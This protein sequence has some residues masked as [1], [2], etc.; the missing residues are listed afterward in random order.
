MGVMPFGSSS[1]TVFPIL[2]ARKFV[3]RSPG[4]IFIA[5]LAPI[6]MPCRR[7]LALLCQMGHGTLCLLTLLVPFR[8]MEYIIT[9]VDFFSKYSI[10][11]PS[12]DHMALMVSNAL[13]DR[14]VSY[15]WEALVE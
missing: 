4:L 2:W 7:P 15:F 11:I 3:S 13:L 8:R 5:R 10:L 1:E 6:M 12:K 9:F 14:V